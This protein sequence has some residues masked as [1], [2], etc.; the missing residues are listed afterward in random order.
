[1]QTETEILAAMKEI[2]G[3]STFKEGQKEA[4]GALLAKKDLLAIMPTGAGKSLC[5]QLPALL[6]GGITLVVSPLVSLMKDQVT[7]L[8]QVGVRAAFLNA[9]LT[10]A[11]YFKA[12]Q[13]AEDGMYKII[14]VA[15]ERLLTDSFLNFARRAP[16]WQVTV[17]EAHCV[18]QW[19]PD[20]RPSYLKIKEFISLLPNRPAVSAFTATAT[21]AV[22]QD[23]LEQL[24]LQAPVLVRTGYDRKNLFFEV[25]HP[26]NKLLALFEALEKN[27]G[28]PA[29]VYCATRKTV[30]EVCEALRAKG[31]LAARYHA[32]LEDAERACSQDDFLFDRAA[33]LVATNAFG[34][35]I[36]KSNVSLVVH[37]NMPK[38]LESY[39][40]EA[41]R[42]GR[43][44]SDA[45]CLLLY[46]GKDVI[47]AQYLISHSHEESGLSPEE[48][49]EVEEKERRALKE[50]TFYCHTTDCLRAF[51]LRYFGEEAPPCCGNCKNCVDGFEEVD[52]IEPA[53][54]VL[55]GIFRMGRPFGFKMVTDLLRGKG[56]ERMRALHFDALPVFGMLR[57]TSEVRVREVLNYLVSGGY[58]SLSEGEYPTLSLTPKAQELLLP[59]AELVMRAKREKAPASA[60]ARPTGPGGAVDEKLLILLRKKRA[61]IAASSR[62]PA[63]VVF[64][65]ASL[66][67]MCQKKPTTRSGLMGIP[68]VGEVKMRRY[69]E[70][71]LNLIRAYLGEDKKGDF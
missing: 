1:M 21:A 54:L 32:G 29:I 56:S 48:K 26:K 61:A 34:M 58:L 53:R 51:L 10:R 28:R 57:E 41:G 14:Y 46:S 45:R 44:G 42:A 65:D 69:G 9:S 66:R 60:P 39:Y 11:Q 6:Q 4:V 18:S 7:A 25:Q 5:Y 8:L 16:I 55:N 37:Y 64:T 3:Y 71:F 38:N 33:V 67:Q 47:T 30:E 35:G 17:D 43:D 27:D 13:N 62:V 2:F 12:L 23:I 40:Q 31:Y 24:Q 63:Y 49:R 52:I 19:G 70:D 68:G 22:E 15:P 50:M 20:F 36:D 59:D